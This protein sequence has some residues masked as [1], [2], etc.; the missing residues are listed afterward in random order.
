VGLTDSRPSVRFLIVGIANTIFGYAT[1]AFLTF[2]FVKW[3]DEGYLLASVTSGVLNITVSFL[4]LK[5]FVFG[6]SGNYLS[7]WFRCVIVYGSS[8]A[9]SVVSLLPLVEMLKLAGVSITYAPYI[10]GAVV[11]AAQACGTYIAHS[12]YTFNR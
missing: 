11:I 12:K 7:E 1:Y 10:A 9:I 5:K 4:S 3:F 2:I 8:S 6:T